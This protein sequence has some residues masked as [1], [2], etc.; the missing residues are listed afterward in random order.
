MRVL[1][2]APLVQG[3][4]DDQLDLL[5]SDRPR[6]ARPRRIGQSLRPVL[7]EPRPPFRNR[8]PG[9]SQ[10]SSTAVTGAPPAQVNTIRARSA[11]F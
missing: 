9:H 2:R 3:L 8:C 1:A 5:I 6:R 7:R 11:S 4:G 10:L